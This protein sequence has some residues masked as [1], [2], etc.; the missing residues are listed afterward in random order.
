VVKRLT[1]RKGQAAAPRKWL[2]HTN[3]CAAQVADATQRSSG[4]ATQMPAA[5]KRL[6]RA[7]GAKCL[8]HAKQLRCAKLLTP[9]KMLEPCKMSSKH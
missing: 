7:K 8:R 1:P 2:R 3:A 4:F 9:S 5:C 6:R